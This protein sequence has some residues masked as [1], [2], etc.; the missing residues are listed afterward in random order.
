MILRKQQNLFQFKTL[1]SLLI[2]KLHRSDGVT[3]NLCNLSRLKLQ[4]NSPI[5]KVMLG[6]GRKIIYHDLCIEGSIVTLG[7]DIC[8][9]SLGKSHE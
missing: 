3:S 6:D 4:R 9:L 2:D 7:I 1:H 5:Q 8:G